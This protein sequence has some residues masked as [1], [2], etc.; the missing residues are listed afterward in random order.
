M[1]QSKLS[2]AIRPLGLI[3]KLIAA[4]VKNIFWAIDVGA[5][6][7]ARLLKFFSFRRL[8]SFSCFFGA[9]AAI[10]AT[11]NSFGDKLEEKMI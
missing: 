10:G 7:S 9:A 1:Y 2:A 3:A 6:E 5:K 8:L 11:K 4:I